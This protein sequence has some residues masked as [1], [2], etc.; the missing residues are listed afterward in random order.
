MLRHW[1]KLQVPMLCCSP[2]PTVS[3]VQNLFPPPEQK[4][5]T[6][7]TILQVSTVTTSIPLRT[8]GTL[9]PILPYSPAPH[10]QTSDTGGTQKVLL[11]ST[12]TLRT[13]TP[14]VF[15]LFPS[16]FL[17]PIGLPN[18][19]YLRHHR[20][21]LSFLQDPLPLLPSSCHLPSLSSPKPKTTFYHRNAPHLLSRMLLK[22]P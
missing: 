5:Q 4:T 9:P 19:P 16:Q 14:L 20:P 22:A 17:T 10:L 11:L 1:C 13:C 12:K 21:E 6:T 15:H 3:Q 18:G 7:G 8:Y 2:F